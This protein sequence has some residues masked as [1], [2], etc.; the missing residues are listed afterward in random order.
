MILY[1]NVPDGFDCVKN[2]GPHLQLQFIIMKDGK[3]EFH[4]I[5]NKPKSY[6]FRYIAIISF[7]VYLLSN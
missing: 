2:Q 1:S 5:D 7:F 4:K 3:A 6:I